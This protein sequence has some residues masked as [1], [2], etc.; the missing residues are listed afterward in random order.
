MAPNAPTPAD[1]FNL[2]ADMVRIG[3]D[4]ASAMHLDL[5][6]RGSFVGPDSFT[7]FRLPHEQMMSFAPFKVEE[8]TVSFSGAG[9]FYVFPAKRRWIG[10]D[11]LWPQYK[12]AVK[13]GRQVSP[14][15]RLRVAKNFS[16]VEERS[17]NF[18]VEHLNAA[19]LEFELPYTSQSAIGAKSGKVELTSSYA[20]I[21]KML[22]SLEE[23]R[24]LAILSPDEW[25]RIVEA[26][27]HISEIVKKS[28]S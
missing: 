7:L 14:S 16:F 15:G 19:Y 8:S 5:L 23:V 18:R 12:E 21:E 9:G 24:G 22:E 28:G 6:L 1:K 20:G 2:L 11:P 13:L 25:E 10:S 4:T 3:F 17:N 26:A 27:K